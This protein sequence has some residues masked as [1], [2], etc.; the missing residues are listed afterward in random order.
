MN[1]ILEGK[2]VTGFYLNMFS[3]KGTVTESRVKYGGKVS[4]TIAL[5]EPIMVFGAVREVVL[6]DS[7]ELT[8]V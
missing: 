8:V 7:E 4:N 2:Q 3:I 6:M 5:D 1:W